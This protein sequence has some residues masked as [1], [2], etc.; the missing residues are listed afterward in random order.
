MSLI[1]GRIL[2]IVLGLVCTYAYVYQIDLHLQYLYFFILGHVIAQN[3][4]YLRMK[5]GHWLAIFVSCNMLNIIYGI[6]KTLELGRYTGVVTQYRNPL[7]VLSAVSFFIF[8]MQFQGGNVRLSEKLQ[9]GVEICCSCS[10]GV[11]LIHIIFLDIYK[12]N[13]TAAAFSAYVIIP[14]LIVMIAILSVGSVYLIRKT[15][16]GRQIT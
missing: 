7:I 13:F 12:Q 14:I 6:K 16:F 10:F 5:Q 9:K 4:P 3:M 1:A 8:V 2:A 15:K 11:Y